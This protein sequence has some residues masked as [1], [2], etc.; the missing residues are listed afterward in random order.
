MALESSCLYFSLSWYF[1]VY[2]TAPGPPPS[3]STSS[4]NVTSI[5]IQWEPVLCQDR[6]HQFNS[7]AVAYHPV[8]DPNIVRTSDLLPEANRVFTASR[9]SP[10]TSY[11]FQVQA[12]NV[13]P[14]VQ[15][16]FANLTVNTSVPTSNMSN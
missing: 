5:T 6:N 10:R 13:F 14:L 11:T 9:L 2:T 8:S 15:G 7:Y 1:V 3:L 4:I 12:F 16:L